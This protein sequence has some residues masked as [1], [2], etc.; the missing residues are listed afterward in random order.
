MHKLLE[1][2]LKKALRSTS[3]SKVDYDTLIEMINTTYE[4]FDK[5]R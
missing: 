4:E 5:K 2:Q 3:D 1:R